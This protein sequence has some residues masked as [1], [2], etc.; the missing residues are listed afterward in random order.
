MSKIEFGYP[1]MTAR[2]Q[3]GIEIVTTTVKDMNPDLIGMYTVLFS[4]VFSIAH[5]YLDTFSSVEL[6]GPQNILTVAVQSGKVVAGVSCK[7]EFQNKSTHYHVKGLVSDGS[8][9]G[10][11]P[12]LISNSM[13]FAM[14]TSHLPVT[15][16]AI[17]REI[18]G[19]PN[20]GSSSAF[21]DVGFRCVERGVGPISLQSAHLRI[22]EQADTDVI[23]V[24]RYFG[25]SERMAKFGRWILEDWK[26]GSQ[27]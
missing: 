25:K 23:A 4:K 24:H 20:V 14:A 9:R 1:I 10:I 17:V 3:D 21:A 7:P 27:V 2:R 26:Q 8:I 12:A 13:R 18:D 15:A 6:L 22:R 19:K 5:L 16:E 11:S